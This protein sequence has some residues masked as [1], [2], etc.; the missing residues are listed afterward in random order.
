MLHLV[1]GCFLEGSFVLVNGGLHAPFGEVGEEKEKLAPVGMMFLH[2]VQH[3]EEWK[4]VW[5]Q[6]RRG[7]T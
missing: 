4:T 7:V 1:P 6:T 5:T 2:S 3:L